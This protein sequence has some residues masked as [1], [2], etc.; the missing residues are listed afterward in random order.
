MNGFENAQ[1]IA[2]RAE[3]TLK[4]ALDEEV[5]DNDYVVAVLDPPRCGVHK[6][7]CKLIGMQRRIQRVIYISCNPNSCIVDAHKLCQTPS[8]KMV[9]TPFKPIKAIGVDLFPHTE[10][11]EMIMHL[12]RCKE[13]EVDWTKVSKQARESQRKYLY[14]QKIKN[15]E[16]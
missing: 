9:G 10:H 5:D 14:A 15:E 13:S 16:K 3:Q 6:D 1:F 12:E 8:K 2:G 11:V 4:K 7:V